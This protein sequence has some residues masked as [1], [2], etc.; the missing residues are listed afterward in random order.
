MDTPSANGLKSNKLLGAWLL[1][2]VRTPNFMSRT[3]C[4]FRCLEYVFGHSDYFLQHRTRSLNEDQGRVESFARRV[5]PTLLHIFPDL[6][7]L[8]IQ[9]TFAVT[10]QQVSQ[11]SLSPLVP[12]NDL[13]S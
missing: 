10:G 11:N 5:F 6:A 7:D 1:S 13:L 4:S 8:E 2:S 12:L 3:Q 9:T